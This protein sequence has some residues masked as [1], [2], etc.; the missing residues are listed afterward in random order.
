MTVKQKCECEQICKHYGIESQKLILMEE[1]AELIQVVS[2]LT[3]AEQSGKT[4]DRTQAMFNLAEEC[5]DVTIMIQQILSHYFENEAEKRL[6]YFINQK[7][8][9][10]IGRIE[11]DKGIS[12][13]AYLSKRWLETR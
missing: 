6:D 4:F 8:T 11:S 13:N 7:L 2:K 1:C 5:A 12:D 9:R 10:Q 3:R